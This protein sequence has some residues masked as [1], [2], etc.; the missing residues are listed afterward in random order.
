MV[1]KFAQYDIFSIAFTSSSLKKNLSTG[2]L[3][4]Y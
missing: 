4:V 1:Y 3:Q 2:I